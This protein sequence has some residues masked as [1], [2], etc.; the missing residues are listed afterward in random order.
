MYNTK[1]A[2][3]KKKKGKNRP[4]SIEDKKNIFNSF[5]GLFTKK[6]F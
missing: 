4:V 5:K 2:K 3:P 1:V 6:I